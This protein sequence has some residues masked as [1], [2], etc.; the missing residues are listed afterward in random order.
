MSYPWNEIKEVIKQTEI[1]RVKQE[2]FELE[3]G[4]GF[5]KKESTLSERMR[6]YFEFL[7]VLAIGVTIGLFSIIFN[8]LLFVWILHIEF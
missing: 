5:V 6:V 8:D 4:E 2:I 1:E 3:Q 7:G